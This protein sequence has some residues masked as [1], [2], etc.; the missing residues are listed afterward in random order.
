MAISPNTNFTTG[1]VLTAD[2]AN[3]W[4]RGVMAF[5]TLT[6][7]T[8][9]NTTETT[10]TSVT[11]TAVADRYYKITW[12]EGNVLNGAN[13]SVNNMYLRQTTTA[14]TVIGN[15]VLYMAA[16]VQNERQCSVTT[17]FAA[18]SQTVFARILSNAATNTTYS[19]SATQPAFLLV[20]DIGPA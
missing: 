12:F 17:T 13:A 10:R 5:S 9:V 4:P 15:S 3:R 8:T 6:A 1:Q 20:E 7:N 2:N 11:W 19:A 16:A 14:G 18:G